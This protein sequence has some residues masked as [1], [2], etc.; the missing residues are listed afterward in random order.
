MHVLISV[1]ALMRQEHQATSCGSRGLKRQLQKTF[2]LITMDTKPASVSRST[3]SI[4]R[5]GKQQKWD[6]TARPWGNAIWR[7]NWRWWDGTWGPEIATTR[8]C[9]SEFL[10]VTRVRKTVLW[11]GSVYRKPSEHRQHITHSQTQSKLSEKNHLSWKNS[12]FMKYYEILM[13][14][15]K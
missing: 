11:P 6:W 14:Y 13:F 4:L 5:K 1:P 8:S 12:N 7:R 10:P 3:I 9:V 2:L 15:G